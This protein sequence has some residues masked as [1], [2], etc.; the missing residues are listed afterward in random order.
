MENTVE[1]SRSLNGTII[2]STNVG[3]PSL[4]T[5]K[6]NKTTTDPIYR[7]FHLPIGKSQITVTD[8][9]TNAQCTFSVWPMNPELAEA[10][11]KAIKPRKSPP[12]GY[13]ENRSQYAIPDEY[14]FPMDEKHIR[15]A[16]SYFDKHKYKSPAQRR[17]AARKMLRAAKK[18]G[19][20]V[21]ED[22]KVY[23]AAH[24]D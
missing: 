18:F 23:S 19:I 9:P 1:A 3:K 4:I 21:S 6:Y 14:R 15:A 2:L 22:S 24:G 20:N 13:P 11:Y 12:K 10:L 17:S 8:V 7:T 5:L 16:L